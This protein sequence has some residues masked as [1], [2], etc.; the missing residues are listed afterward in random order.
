MRLLIEFI[1]LLIIL[2]LIFL[3][4]FGDWL[5]ENIG[6]RVLRTDVDINKVKFS[7]TG[8]VFRLYGINLPKK[9]II[10]STGKISLFPP[11]LEFY[12]LKIKNE[13]LLGERSFSIDIS[14]HRNW[15]ISVLFKGVDLS[16]L[17]YGFKKGELS[18]TVDGIYIRGNCELYGVLSIKNIG[19]LDLDGEFLG[20]S[21]R[22][23]EELSRIYNGKLELDFTYNGPIGKIDEFY[24]YMPGR[25]TMGLV[26][27]YLLKKVLK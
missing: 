9:N 27:T 12:G 5:L 10:I 13:I 2:G 3:A 20:I 7:S 23:L 18:G 17:G 21:F 11:R 25:K 1:I 16:R 8:L 15:E 26:K 4:V 24:R 6:A 14:R 22:D 19:F